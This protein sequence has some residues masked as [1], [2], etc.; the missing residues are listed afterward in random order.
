MAEMKMSVRIGADI[1]RVYQALTDQVQIRRWWTEVCSIQPVEGST[2]RVD[3]KPDRAWVEFG[4]AVLDPDR[5]VE[6][7]VTNSWMVETEDWNGTV[8]RFRLSAGSAGGSILE[9]VHSG[10]REESRCFV[11]CTAGWQFYLGD[12]LKRYLETGQG[13][14]Y[15]EVLDQALIG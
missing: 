14:P 3:F 13:E 9:F 6:W 5:L 2:G 1:H 7:Q 12:S 8:I 11:A 15:P 4:V 10:W